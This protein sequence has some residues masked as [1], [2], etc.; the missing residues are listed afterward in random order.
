MSVTKTKSDAYKVDVNIGGYPRLR[1]TVKT[2]GE[3][4]I[5]EASILAAMKEGKP[6]AYVKALLSNPNPHK[7]PQDASVA[8]IQDSLWEALRQVGFAHYDGSKNYIGAN[9]LVNEVIDLLKPMTPLGEIKERHLDALVSIWKGRGLNNKTVN[10]KLSTASILL[11]KAVRKEWLNSMPI[12]ERV[13]E[14]AGRLLHYDDEMLEDFFSNLSETTY[15]DTTPFFW[16]LLDTGCRLGEAMK[17]TFKDINSHKSV[18]FRNTKNGKDR[19][20]PL[21]QRLRTYFEELDADTPWPMLLPRKTAP[22]YINGSPVIKETRVRKGFNAVKKSLGWPDGYV[23]HTFRHT[24]ATRLVQKNIHLAA[25]MEW[26]GHTNIATTM[27]YIQLTDEH[28]QEALEALE[29]S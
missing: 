23:K 29:S 25:I 20:V 28:L 21:T 26:M 24:C 7:A 17:L 8:I 10:R 11:K 16:F 15:K 1:K 4:L 27:L 12:I 9:R 14:S 6:T 2:E 3:A 19:T 18:T 22:R 13:P 5:L